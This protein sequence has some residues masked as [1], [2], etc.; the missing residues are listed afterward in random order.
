LKNSGRILFAALLLLGSRAYPAVEVK[1]ELNRRIVEI[2]E[3]A[4]LSITIPGDPSGIDPKKV[5]SVKG[6]EIEY[7]GMSMSYSNING[8]VTRGVVLSFRVR[9]LARGKYAIPSFLFKSSRDVYRSKPV[10][11]LV[12]KGVGKKLEGVGGYRS[13]TEISS[14]KVYLGEPVILRYFLLMGGADQLRIEGIERMPES[15]G[16]IIKEIEESIDDEVVTEKGLE[17]Y[18]SH[19]YSYMLV[20]ME[21]G[22]KRAGRSSLIISHS[23]PH[24]FFSIMR[25]RRLNFSDIDLEVLPVP[26]KG[27]P[28]D[29]KGDIGNFTIDAEYRDDEIDVFQEKIINLKISGT[30]NFL[31]LSKPEVRKKSDALRVILEEKSSKINIVQGKIEGEKIF[32]LTIIPNE[33]G[34][35]DLGRIGFSFFDPDSGKF[36]SAETDEIRFKVTG[37]GKGAGS[38][39]DFESS[40]KGFSTGII[41]G[42]LAA[43]VI[44]FGLFFLFERRSLK[45]VEGKITRNDEE[46]AEE[47]ERKNGADYLNS[48]KD[49]VSADD[50]RGFL[51]AAENYLNALS[52]AGEKKSHGVELNTLKERV[53][54]CRYGGGN[55]SRDE[56]TELLK[57]MEELDKR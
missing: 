21:T 8:N 11:L 50:P 16:F 37:E 35:Y 27:R 43:V 5:P 17:L 12:K 6:L 48:M 49:A 39:K 46:T 2:G 31:S 7:Y 1:T 22:Q 18:K 20:P 56:M 55:I 9:A 26:E 42:V 3:T 14:E 15:K 13:E 36:G 10:T 51:Q 41:A 30:G 32:R 34:D 40:G 52:G 54:A 45:R 29:Y 28:G 47:A 44:A 53:F 19:L 57:E 38:G 4:T 33:P 24:S 25:K 23:D